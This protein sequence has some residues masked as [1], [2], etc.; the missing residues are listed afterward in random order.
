MNGNK[1]GC[2]QITGKNP[3]EKSYNL[4]I[5]AGWFYIWSERCKTLDGILLGQQDLFLLYLQKL[6]WKNQPLISDDKKFLNDLLKNLIF[7]YAISATEIKRLLKEFAIE[8]GSLMYFSSLVIYEDMS[9]FLC[10]IGTEVLIP[11]QVLFISLMFSFKKFVKYFCLAILI[12]AD[13]R[14]L[15]FLWY[16]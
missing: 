9:L 16:L 6:S 4:Q 2:P 5:V 10:F 14:F 11:F 8:K 3:E 13:K 1:L 7:A 15:Q 12:S